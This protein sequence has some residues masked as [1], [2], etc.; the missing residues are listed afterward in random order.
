[1]EIKSVYVYNYIINCLAYTLFK[2]PFILNYY[3]KII[4]TKINFN[5]IVLKSIEEYN[6]NKILDCASGL[7]DPMYTYIINCLAYTLFKFA[8][9]NVLF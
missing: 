6:T 3:K 8:I 1:M 9:I 2:V 7:K 4:K 5:N